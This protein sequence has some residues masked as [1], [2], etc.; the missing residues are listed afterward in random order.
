[1]AFIDLSMTI[2][3]N[4]RWPAEVRLERDFDRGDPYRVTSLKAGMHS[5]TH[6]DSPL[7]I[8]PGRET[9]DQV[10]LERLCGPAAIVDLGPVEPNRS[11]GRGLF[12]GRMGHLIPNDILILKT[13][14]DLT[15]D[16]ST[17]EYW[18]EA[19]YLDEEAAAWLSELPIKAVGFDFPQDKVIR[20]IPSR[21]PAVREMPTHDLILRKGILLIEY[22]CNLHRIRSKRVEIFAL[23]L[24]VAGAE[25]ACARVVAVEG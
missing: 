3:P 23:P 15:R 2:R 6:V 8:E 20:E 22:L 12:E 14:W 18:S 24:K 9:I 17:R 1:M 10:E 5:F 7:H 19:P 21:H 4:W 16:S 13:C 11:I 25:G